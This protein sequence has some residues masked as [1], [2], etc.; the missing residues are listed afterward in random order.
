MMSDL[1]NIKYQ[2]FEH[3]SEIVSQKINAINNTLKEVQL[4]ANNET[5]SSAGDKHETGRAMAQLETEKLTAQLSETLKLEQTLHQINPNTQHKIIGLGSLIITNNG[6]F[7]ITVSLGKILYNE[8]AYYAISAVSPL[9]KQFIGLKQGYELVF[10]K[11][12]YKIEK[13]G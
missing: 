12:T 6:N 13:I 11:R 3:C 2:L 9:G 8:K 4:A 5:K 1:K 10:N 7:Y